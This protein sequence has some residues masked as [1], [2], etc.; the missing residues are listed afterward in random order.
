MSNDKER[1]D[2]LDD[3]P[4]CIGRLWP[5]ILAALVV[6]LMTTGCAP[7]PTCTEKAMAQWREKNPNGGSA[8]ASYRYRR[9]QQG[10]GEN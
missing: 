10:C 5:Y 2:C 6:I 3:L 4:D 7:E 9:F 8:E 1:K